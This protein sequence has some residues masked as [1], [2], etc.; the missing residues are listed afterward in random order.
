MLQVCDFPGCSTLT[1]GPLCLHHEPA[2]VHR[3]YPRGRPYPPL[4]RLLPP[5]VF[6]EPSAKEELIPDVVLMEGGA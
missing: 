6:S 1:I 5:R 3:I 4:Q 2:P